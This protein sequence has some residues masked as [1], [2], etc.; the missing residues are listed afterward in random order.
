[1]SEN[2]DLQWK[3]VHN[4]GRHAHVIKNGKTFCGRDVS[5]YNKE[6]QHHP[7]KKC[8]RCAE[9]LSVVIFNQKLVTA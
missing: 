6:V 8:K 3:R 2:P 4:F 7:T 9:F 5:N 1:M